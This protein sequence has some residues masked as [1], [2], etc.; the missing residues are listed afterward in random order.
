MKNNSVIPCPS[1]KDGIC[2]LPI[3]IDPYQ[4]C[5]FKCIYC[6]S[7][8]HRAACRNP[9]TFLNKTEFDF[10]P[11]NRM[12]ER[13]LINKNKAINFLQKL[14]ADGITWHCGG[15]SD[16]FQHCEKELKAT[17]NMIEVTNKYDISILFSTKSDTVYGSNIRPDLHSFQL[18]V[19]NV[20]NRKD[21]EPN[22]PDIQ[23]RID[24]Y[25]ELKKNGFKV[26]IRVQPFIIGISN[27]E[28]V[29]VFHDADYFTLEGLKLTNNTE[30]NEIIKNVL[31]LVDSDFVFK[32]A[33]FYILPELRFKAYQPFFEKLKKYNIPHSLGDNDMRWITSGKC[34][35]GDPLIKKST[36]F[37]VTAM[38]HKCG[39]NYSCED[40]IREMGDYFY[41]KNYTFQNTGFKKQFNAQIGANSIFNFSNERN[42]SSPKF[43]WNP[44]ENF[45][46]MT[47]FEE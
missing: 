18:S 37:N 12:L 15:M 35:C 8:N 17:Q 27:E 10:E 3:R 40:L 24:F 46:L 26:G 4:E 44:I 45:D 22:V 9:E 1:R 14:I 36:D 19:S 25:R 43:Q 29:D 31:G 16:P 20:N 47:L 6:F 41:L 2:G 38:I 21:I 5:S 7:N 39:Q 11:L 13:I 33:N 28:I 42:P 32:S 23:S 30:M 34:C